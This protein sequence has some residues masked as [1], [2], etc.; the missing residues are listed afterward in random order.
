M[1]STVIDRLTKTYIGKQSTIALKDDHVKSDLSEK[2]SLKVTEPGG[3]CPDVVPSRIPPQSS[4]KT[5]YTL[6]EVSD[7]CD[8]ESCWVVLW[9]HVYDVT[10]FV[11]EVG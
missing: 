7:H 11:R 8:P 9:D 2:D 5:V 10:K 6:E 3:L 1:L 4:A